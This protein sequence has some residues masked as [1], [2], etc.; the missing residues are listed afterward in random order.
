[1]K[2][3]KI[4]DLHTHTTFS[5][6]TKTPTELVKYAAVK[7]LSAVAV[8]DHDCMDGLEEA[9]ACGKQVG[10]EVVP[11][12]EISAEYENDE[13]HI[14][15]LFVDRNNEELKKILKDTREKRIHRNKLV[16]E[17]INALGIPLTYEEVEKAAD[18]GII[19]RAHF[20][21]ALLKNG[22]VTSIKEAFD[23]YIGDNKPAYIRRELPSWN[24]AVRFIKNAGGAAVL[25]HP[26]LYKVGQKR[27]EKIISDL[28]LAGLY[29]IEAYYPT[30]SPSDVKYIKMIAQ[31]YRL[32]LSGGSDYH[33]DNKPMLDL[34]TGYGNLRV[35][36]ELL[37][38][39]RKR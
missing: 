8:T 30:H 33:G 9:E 21:R 15:G 13:V 35:P 29:G 32:K 31:K 22:Y 20:A 25:A 16:V 19:T 28:S 3:E 34:G 26:L 14:V 10:V 39:L 37:E 5:D 4:I 18:G 6:G 11:G 23:R 2:T 38:E 27:L 17:K 36:Y 24:E 7:G 1:M 12:I